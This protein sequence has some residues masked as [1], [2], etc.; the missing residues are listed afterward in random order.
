VRANFCV[1]RWFWHNGRL[2]ALQL[3]L[4]GGHTREAKP[5]PGNP[6]ESPNCSVTLIG[7]VA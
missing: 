3:R 7:E 4:L 6:P 5:D 2:S 1:D